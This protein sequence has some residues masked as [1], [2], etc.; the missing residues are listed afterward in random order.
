MLV[1]PLADFMLQSMDTVSLGMSNLITELP[2]AL[3]TDLQSHSWELIDAGAGK[4]ESAIC[5]SKIH[6]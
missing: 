5:E 1:W 4:S 6:V 3:L 2:M